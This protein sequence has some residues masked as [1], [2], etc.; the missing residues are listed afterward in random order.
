M[1]DQLAGQTCIVLLLDREP[2]LSACL[3]RYKLAVLCASARLDLK[4]KMLEY[5]AVFKILASLSTYIR[6]GVYTFKN[7]SQFEWEEWD[8]TGMVHGKYSTRSTHHTISLWATIMTPFF[9]GSF[10]A[11]SVEL[12]IQH[13]SVTL[14]APR[15]SVV[16][17]CLFKRTG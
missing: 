7:H 6:R 8:G 11:V 1:A 9:N 13:H 16:A 10:S 5:K 17:G 15:D 2:F 3:Y 4:S 14:K 12:N